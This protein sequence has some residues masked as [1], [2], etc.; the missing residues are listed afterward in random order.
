MKMRIGLRAHGFS[1]ELSVGLLAAALT[2]VPM[3]ALI[4]GTASAAPLMHGPSTTEDYVPVV[5]V[6]DVPLIERA[7]RLDE[8]QRAILSALAADL[9]AGT[10]GRESSIGFL[11]SLRAILTDE[12]IA[13]IPDAL[14][15]IRRERMQTAANIAGESI[16]VGMLA[17]R[18]LRGI[19]VD[20]ASQL[21]DQYWRELDVLLAAR[22]SATPATMM[23]ADREQGRRS[24]RD[25]SVD[26]RGSAAG[27]R[28]VLQTR[29]FIRELNDRAIAELTA[30]M[31]EALA[32]DFELNALAEAYPNAYVPSGALEQL[33]AIAAEHP[34]PAL[35]SLRDEAARRLDGLRRNAVDAI[36]K[37][38]AAPLSGGEAQVGADKVIAKCEKEYA[39]FESWLLE[40]ITAAES[41][42]QLAKTSAGRAL[43]ERA[44]V[45]ELASGHNWDD[46]Q[47]TVSRFDTDGDGQLSGDESSQI[48]DAYV[49]SMGKR[50]RWRL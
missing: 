13:L 18:H 45:A 14:R 42:E 43:L 48:L 30:A 8:G 39:D 34:S 35:V 22:E 17:Q 6:R 10:P 47:A 12:Q 36:R 32:R 49:R 24:S 28:E 19:A 16:D 3:A 33:K 15:E 27:S 1:A 41:P 2:A 9:A 38:D 44:K 37:R 21:I 5:L 26:A 46:Q 11:E 4:A 7:L 40:A 31:P 29:V 20:G 50:S 25:R 23:N